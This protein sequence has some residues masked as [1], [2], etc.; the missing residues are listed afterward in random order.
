MSKFNSEALIR[1]L[2]AGED[3][4]ADIFQKTFPKHLRSFKVICNRLNE[5]ISDIQIK[6]PDACFY[7]SD[8]GDLSILL[9]DCFNNDID[10]STA[11]A[12][13]IHMLDMMREL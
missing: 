2:E 1:L 13:R 3:D 10:V 8:D 12:V 6:F 5:L 11:T 7:V 9:C 4:A